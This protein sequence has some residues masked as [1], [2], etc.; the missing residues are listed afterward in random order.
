MTA[1]RPTMR[2]RSFGLVAATVLMMGTI[3]LPHSSEA[4]TTPTYT[5]FASDYGDAGEPS[6]GV[7]WVTG[8][9]MFQAGFNTA[10]VDT[11]NDTTKTAEWND[12]T[13]LLTVSLDPILFTDHWTNRTFVS[14]LYGACSELSYT[15]NDGTSWIGNAAGCALGS[16]ADHQTV[17]GGPMPPPLAGTLPPPAYPDALYYCSQALVTSNCGASLNGGVAFNPATP[18]YRPG[19]CS[20]LNGHIKVAA[21]GT[22]YLPHGRCGG[23]QAVL[24]TSNIGA[25]WAL[26]A[27]PDSTASN[28][29]DPSV[30]IGAG[31]KV[32][33]GYQEPTATGSVARVAV[34]S[35]KGATWLPSLTVGGTTIKNVQFPTIVAGDN[36]RAAFAFLGTTS[37]GD[38][39]A[40][41]FAGVWHLYVATTYDGGATWVTVDATPTDPVQRGTIC[42]GGIGC[43]SGRN[44][45]DFN[46]MDID[47]Q[48]R[49]YVA[50]ADGCLGCTSASGST[51]AIGTIARQST[52]TDLCAAVSGCAL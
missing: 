45:L 7:N 2:M 51:A 49:I 4:F 40:S 21:D 12:V 22:A 18:S 17:G 5:N 37:S 28:E 10:R 13:P 31:G 46:G 3:L 9:V 47:K 43:G 39:Q 15:D 23:N 20:G 50:Y 14:H 42:M 48:G 16:A 27:I 11:F 32:Y 52:G 8:E 35:D 34:S 24:V 36:D 26:R 1:N 41:T 6:I 38:D 19:F 30:A 33:F 25:T 29:G 44:L